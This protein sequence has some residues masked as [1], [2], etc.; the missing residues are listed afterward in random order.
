[1]RNDVFI[2]GTVS[3]EMIK[4]YIYK[5]DLKI[6]HIGVVQEN[7]CKCASGMEPEAHRKN[8]V[9]VMFTLTKVKEG[10]ITMETCTQQ[11][12]TFHQTKKTQG[13][14]CENGGHDSQSRS[15]YHR[16]YQL[17]TI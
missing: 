13:L 5:V 2:P 12:Q 10:I 7:Q 1:V 3:A 4:N 14:T 15:L 17:T 16:S 8:V 9:L 11:L 6:E